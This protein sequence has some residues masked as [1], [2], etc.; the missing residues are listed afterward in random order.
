MLEFRVCRSFVGSSRGMDLRST[1]GGSL[2]GLILSLLHNYAFEGPVALPVPYS[3]APDFPGYCLPEVIPERLDGRSFLLGLLC[4]AA[5][6][7]VLDLLQ[8][9]RI[10]FRRLRERLTLWSQRPH[11]VLNKVNER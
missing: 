5:L 11:V 6:G 9:V 2:G 7:P 8:A 3:G 10:Y 4:G 1:A